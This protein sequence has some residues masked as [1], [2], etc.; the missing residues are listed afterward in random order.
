MAGTRRRPKAA[1]K[2][3][4]RELSRIDWSTRVLEQAFDQSLPL[5]ERVKYCAFFSSHLDEFFA[6]RVAGLLAQLASGLNVRSD[7]GLSPK[8]TLAEIRRRVEELSVRHARL[9]SRE[10]CPALAGEGI[11]IG[12]VDDCSDEE[13][14]ELATRFRQDIYPVLTP[15]AVGPGQ[16]FPYISPLSLSLAVFVR[17]PESGE[18]RLAR[19]KVPEGNRGSSRSAPGGCSSRSR[20]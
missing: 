14:V 20:T 12:R 1:E 15:L 18:E 13:R 2:L 6:V 19:V 8:A 3:I 16:P 17:D 10:L 4:N 9:W 5:L 7:D 11:V